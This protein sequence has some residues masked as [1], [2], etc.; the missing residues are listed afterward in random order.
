MKSNLPVAGGSL[1]SKPTWSNTFGCMTTSV[2][3]LACVGECVRADRQQ[4][5]F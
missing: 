3:F 1:T 4:D 2:F 5:A